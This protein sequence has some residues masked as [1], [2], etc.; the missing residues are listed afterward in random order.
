MR[1]SGPLL[2]T[3]SLIVFVIDEIVSVIFLWVNY[4][5]K[6]QELLQK[7]IFSINNIKT[8]ND[9]QSYQIVASNEIYTL[10]FLNFP[11]FDFT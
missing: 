9:S 11:P 6:L 1:S 4:K 2:H 7:I 5:K 8:K 3:T 10:H